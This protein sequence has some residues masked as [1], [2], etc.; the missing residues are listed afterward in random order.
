MGKTWVLTQ[1]NTKALINQG[2][3]VCFWRRRRDSTLLALKYIQLIELNPF[4]RHLPVLSTD[5][6]PTLSDSQIGTPRL[7]L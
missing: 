1:K 7:I 4:L 6:S 5:S 3:S 2:L